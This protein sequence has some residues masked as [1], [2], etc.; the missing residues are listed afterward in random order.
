MYGTPATFYSVPMARMP[1]FGDSKYVDGWADVVV[2]LSL[3]YSTQWDSLARVGAQFDADGDGVEEAVYYNGYRAGTDLVGPSDDAA[4]D[5]SGHRCF[6]H[7]LG[8][9][10]IDRK[11]VV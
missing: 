1:D 9:E 5:G 4:G 8:L 2:T 10:H 7:H 6:A 3:Q 11:S